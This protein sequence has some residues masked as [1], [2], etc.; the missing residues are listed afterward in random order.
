MGVYIVE[1]VFGTYFK[2]SDG[3][4]VSTRAIAEDHCLED[5]SVIPSL[6]DYLENMA[7]QPWMNG[8]PTEESCPSS[9][10]EIIKNRRKNTKIIKVRD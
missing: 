8:Q 2:N 10:K 1:Q 7:L 3:L 9:C 5:L 4:D 6:Q